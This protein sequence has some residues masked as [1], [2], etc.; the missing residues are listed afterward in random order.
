MLNSSE[1]EEEEEVLAKSTE[2]NEKFSS[3]TFYISR[4]LGIL[5][6][7]LYNIVFLDDVTRHR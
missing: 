6:F 2:A 1:E 4:D 3:P 7:S 5:L